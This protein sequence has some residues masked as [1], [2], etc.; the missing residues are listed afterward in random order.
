VLCH[1][2]DGSGKDTQKASTGVG[3]ATNR[4][5]YWELGQIQSR[6][7]ARPCPSHLPPSLR[8]VG[9]A[10]SILPRLSTIRDILDESN[11]IGQHV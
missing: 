2:S 7:F 4:I 3:N 1:S 9:H 6:A 8:H 5:R 11:N 10:L